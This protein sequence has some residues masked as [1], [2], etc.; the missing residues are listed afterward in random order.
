MIKMVERMDAGSIIM[1]QKTE[2]GEDEDAAELLE[3][4][5]K[6]GAELVLKALEVIGS[7]KEELFEQ[8]ENLA[9]YAP[10]LKKKEGEIDWQLSAE[11]IMRKVR[12]LQPWPGAFT[13]LDGKMLKILEAQAETA[14]QDCRTK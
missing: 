9:T 12:G 2:I 3:R 10:K 13:Y 5:A 14:G 7:D 1:Q 4:L 6:S 11:E 8:D